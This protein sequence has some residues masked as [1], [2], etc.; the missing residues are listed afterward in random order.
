MQ[1][2]TTKLLLLD[3]LLKETMSDTD[4]NDR[5][6]EYG[7]RAGPSGLGR[8]TASESQDDLIDYTNLQDLIELT[9]E[10]FNGSSSTGLAQDDMELTSKNKWLVIDPSYYPKSLEDDFFFKLSDWT[11]QEHARFTYGLLSGTKNYII[12]ISN[13]TSFASIIN[14]PASIEHKEFKMFVASLYAMSLVHMLAIDLHAS[15]K[16]YFPGRI[17]GEVDDVEVERNY[18][19][20][21]VRHTAIYDD[22]AKNIRE[23]HEAWVADREYAISKV[24]NALERQREAAAED[25]PKAK[26]KSEL[27]T[28][29][30]AKSFNNKS[31]LISFIRT[32]ILDHCP[33]I[34][35]MAQVLKRSKQSASLSVK[36]KRREDEEEED[37]E[38]SFDRWAD[39]WIQRS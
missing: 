15:L 1:S 3:S 20:S 25:D 12:S 7:V 34:Y 22:N 14:D 4:G 30:K 6:E 17:E 35:S 26:L 33:T 9:R 18:A 37:E 27:I 19:A 32:W 21:L 5:D 2:K 28:A 8:R 36:R 29:Q 24:K 39:Q 10:G 13:K 16:A 38:E 31:D 11:D 23:A